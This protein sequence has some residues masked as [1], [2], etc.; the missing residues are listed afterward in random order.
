MPKVTNDDL[1]HKLDGIRDALGIQTTTT[2]SVLDNIKRDLDEV[3]GKLTEADRRFKKS[4]WVACLSV[5]GVSLV[6]A[7]LIGGV[8]VLAEIDPVRAHDALSKIFDAV[9][10]GVAM[11]FASLYFVFRRDKES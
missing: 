5:P 4:L 10:L 11:I 2:S 7:G 9:L 8:S 6:F 3:K 1:K